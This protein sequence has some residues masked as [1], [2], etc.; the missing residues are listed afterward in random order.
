MSAMGRRLAQARTS[1]TSALCLRLEVKR[2]LCRYRVSVAIDPSETLPAAR[3]QTRATTPMRG[4]PE[5]QAHRWISKLFPHAYVRDD[6]HEV[7][8]LRDGHVGR[9]D[10][11]IVKHNYG[12]LTSEFQRNFFRLPAAALMMSLPTSVEPVNATCRRLGVR[13]VWRPRF[14]RTRPEYKLH[15]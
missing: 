10:V 1:A 13:R 15:R 3:H 7:A 4:L 14:R 9:P 12:G 6:G 11:G 8:L 2:T 5:H